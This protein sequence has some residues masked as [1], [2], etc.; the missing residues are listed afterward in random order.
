MQSLPWVYF[1]GK[2]SFHDWRER[3]VLGLRGQPL[4]QPI[5]SCGFIYSGPY[6]V[7]FAHGSYREEGYHGVAEEANTGGSYG[8]SIHRDHIPSHCRRWILRANLVYAWVDDP[9]CFGTL[10]EIGWAQA[11]EKLVYLAFAEPAL[12]NDMWFATKLGRTFSGVHST[13]ESG[14]R[15]A[16]LLATG[17]A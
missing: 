8:P 11:A 4:G 13:A 10:V 2:V 7:D 17:A 5:Q 3:L 16:L 6:F 14:L 12:A 15:K 1:A 9:T